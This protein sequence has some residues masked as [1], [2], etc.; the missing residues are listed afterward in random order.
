MIL[1]CRLLI[2]MLCLSSTALGQG[3]SSIQTGYV[4]V[5]PVEG[6]GE[7]LTVL[8]RL[9]NQADGVSFHGTVW[10]GAGVITTSLIVSS[11]SLS[12]LDTGIALVN[13]N[14]FAADITLTLRRENG[15][16][17]ATRIITLE[18]R[19]QISRFISEIFSLQQELVLTGFLSISSTVP[20]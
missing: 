3:S 4:A 14:D 20:L 17:V 13:P 6:F 11:D 5:T 19:R 16:I 1:I 2:A 7:G 8:G 9:E 18:R 15:Q 12:G 10:S